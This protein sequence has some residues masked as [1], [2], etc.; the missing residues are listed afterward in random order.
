MGFTNTN[1]TDVINSLVK[2]NINILQNPL[3][4]FNDKKATV[5]DYYNKDVNLSTL[6]EASGIEYDTIGENCPS[7]FNMIQNAL[8]YGIEKI[9][10]HYTPEDDGV[11]A[12]DIMGEAYVL[13]NTFVPQVGDFFEIKYI[14]ER[15]LFIV[16][17][18]QTDTLDNGNNFYKIGYKLDQT[19]IERIEDLQKY[20]VVEHFNMLTSTVGTSMKSII[21]STDYDFITE[22]EGTTSSLKE[23]YKQLFF[24]NPI[25]TFSYVLNDFHLYDPYLIEFLIR[26]K[27]LAGTEEYVYVDHAMHVWETFGI[28]YDRTFFRALEERSVEKADKCTT[29]AVAPKVN[30]TLSLMTTR[31]DDYYYIDYRINAYAPFMTKIE[32]ISNKLIDC[33]I[34]KSDKL[35]E[36]CPKFYK[37]IIDYFKDDVS[38]EPEDMSLLG[39]IDYTDTKELFYMIPI[40]IYILER[41][42]KEVL[43]SIDDA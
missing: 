37:I 19:G 41:R 15:V 10:L 28:D 3:Y 11:F 9:Q 6:D 39:D 30:D 17:E 32:V 40:L 35:D 43:T 4:I 18:V 16:N 5:V 31:I 22:I 24:K 2:T 33:I 12:D 38:I 34:G 7:K 42:I 27:I 29:L 36:H 23:Y 1:Y 20:N 14:K 8:L 13:P 25:Q 21:K 26:N